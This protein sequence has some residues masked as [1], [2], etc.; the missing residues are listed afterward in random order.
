[1]IKAA[2]NHW[3]ASVPAISDVSNIIFCLSLEPLPPIFYGRHAKDNALGLADRTRA[4]VVALLTATWSNEA[5]DR[6]VT[7]TTNSLL[8]AINDETRQ[9][10][11]LDNFV[12]L[13]YAGQFQDPI[14]SY[15]VDSVNRL[16]K[17]R[18]RADPE[19]V[20]T[21]QVPGG[22]KIPKS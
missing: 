19:G 22:Y 4:L 5:D 9:L 2:Y 8:S 13:N 7:N 10:G 20:F 11:G 1:V 3:N 21:S 17:V 14:G 6:L 18:E 15:G 12:Y 16:R